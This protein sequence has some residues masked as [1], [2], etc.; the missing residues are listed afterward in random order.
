MTRRPAWATIRG[1]GE[2]HDKRP[3]AN[4]GPHR[5]H[6]GGAEHDQCGCEHG[7]QWV[8]TDRFYFDDKVGDWIR[9]RKVPA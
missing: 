2:D 7:N 9:K 6:K 5:C 4:M 3:C 1:T 8:N